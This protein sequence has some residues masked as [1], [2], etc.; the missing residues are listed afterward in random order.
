M[1][2]FIGFQIYNFIKASSAI[3]LDILIENHIPLS[4][5]HQIFL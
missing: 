2:K 4:Q 5:T 1:N 3:I